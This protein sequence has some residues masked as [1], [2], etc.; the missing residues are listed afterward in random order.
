MPDYEEIL[1][2]IKKNPKNVF[3][4]DLLK[5]VELAGWKARRTSKG[6]YILAKPGFFGALTIAQMHG[7]KKLK[8]SYVKAVLKL[9]GEGD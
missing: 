5:L 9:L 7:S 8:E 3:V 6:H 1:A 4:V 2:R